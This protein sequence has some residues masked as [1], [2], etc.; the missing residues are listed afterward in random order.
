MAETALVPTDLLTHK[1]S[2]KKI[3]AIILLAALSAIKNSTDPSI[4]LVNI[5]I[6]SILTV[7]HKHK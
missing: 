4:T 3:S 6:I 7:I 1:K 2:L 5:L